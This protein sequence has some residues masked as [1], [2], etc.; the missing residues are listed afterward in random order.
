VGSEL[1][2][3]RPGAWQRLGSLEKLIAVA[4]AAIGLWGIVL[5]GDG[6]LLKTKALTSAPPYAAQCPAD[7]KGRGP[8]MTRPALHPHGQNTH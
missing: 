2:R 5:I 3:K 6:L 8:D 1:P 4:I 7:G